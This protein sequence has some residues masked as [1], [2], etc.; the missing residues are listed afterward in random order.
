M[1]TH[2]LFALTLGT[3]CVGFGD[4]ASSIE[5]EEGDTDTDGDRDD[6]K[7]E[8]DAIGQDGATILRA[9]STLTFGS[10]IPKSDSPGEFVGF[11]IT[12]SDGSAIDYVVK[13]GGELHPSNASVWIH[14]A[15]ADGGENA[16]GISNVDTCDDEEPPGDE[17]PD[18]EPPPPPPT[19]D[20]PVLT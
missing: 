7:I 13:A 17:P 5:G 14:P 11:T 1:R 19:D 16:P 18:D 8:G 15:G 3:G 6:C 2:L 4:T 9:S 20:G 10:W 12:A